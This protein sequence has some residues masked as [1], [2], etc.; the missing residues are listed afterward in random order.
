MAGKV[1][2]LN[3]SVTAAVIAFEAK[4][5]RETGGID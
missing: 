1:D 3:V 5:R 4:R 2:S